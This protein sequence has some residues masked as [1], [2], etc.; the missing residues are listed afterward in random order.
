MG[1]EN[2]Y[3]HVC[4]KVHLCRKIEFLFYKKY[5]Q[6]KYG[7][8]YLPVLSIKI[9][10]RLSKSLENDPL[11]I[12]YRLPSAPPRKDITRISDIYPGGRGGGGE[13]YKNIYPAN[14]FPR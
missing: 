11:T 13:K 1:Y 7:G 3:S 14:K 12:Q 9:T 10:F 8:S 6:Q 4:S 2:L 5:F